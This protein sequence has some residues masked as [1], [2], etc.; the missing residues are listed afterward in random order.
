MPYDNQFVKSKRGTDLKRK[1]AAM[2]SLL[3]SGSWFRRHCS[4]FGRG[5]VTASTATQ[6][7]WESRYWCCLPPRCH[8][9]TFGRGNEKA[10]KLWWESW[11]RDIESI[12]LMFLA[13]L[14]FWP[15]RRR[16]LC[17]SKS[18]LR[19]AYSGRNK[20]FTLFYVILNAGTGDIDRAVLLDQMWIKWSSTQDVQPG[21]PILNHDK[22]EIGLLPSTITGV[23]L[24]QIR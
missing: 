4:T 3:I 21:D 9:S 2:S 6:L 17:H 11:W 12:L 24:G 16:R 20:Q 18:H 1:F 15:M 14:S 22:C 13:T 19:S 10:T 23:K 8:C 5:N 7:W